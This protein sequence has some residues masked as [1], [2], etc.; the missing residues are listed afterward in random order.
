LDAFLAT[1]LGRYCGGRSE[2]L[3]DTTRRREHPNSVRLS[4]VPGSALGIVGWQG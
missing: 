3:D 1:G 2:W 4:S